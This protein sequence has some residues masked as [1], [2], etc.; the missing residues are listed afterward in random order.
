MTNN[1]VTVD[2]GRRIGEFPYD[3]FMLREDI[4]LHRATIGMSD[5]T[6]LPRAPWERH[7]G[8]G[9]FIE[10]LSTFEAERGMY[11][12]DIPG[13]EQTNPEKHLY[14][15]EIFILSGHGVTQV[16]QGDSKKI[17]FEWGRGSVFAIPPNTT[18]FLANT[19]NVPVVYMGITTAPRVMDSLYDDA[20]VFN[21]DFQFLDLASKTDNY[22]LEPEVRGV[23]GWYKHGTLATHFIP[24]AHELVIDND[25]MGNKIQGGQITS[26]IMG[27]RFPRGHVS[28]WPTGRYHKAHFHG[29]GAVLLG[30]DGEGYALAWDADLGARPY[31]NGH[32]EEVYRVEWGE[33]SIYSPPNHWFHQ[34]FNTGPGPA[35]H[36]AVHAEHF[37]LGVHNLTEPDGESS[38]LHR[39]YKEGGTLI[40]Y[41]DEDP[42]IRQDFAADLSR[43]NLKCVMDE[44]VYSD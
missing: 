25:E 21:S 24:N 2:Q 12:V 33:N 38:R 15:E 29:A 6:A 36:I 32:G 17:T 4:P 42:Q 27:P 1:S 44:V 26:Y 10:L 3:D 13:G 14:E 20:I 22:F 7:G 28:S 9:A 34:H 19:T 11:V 30:L 41:E 5:V 23:K 18:H 37:P 8:N 16:W 35:R 43:N 39:S 31:H 40:N